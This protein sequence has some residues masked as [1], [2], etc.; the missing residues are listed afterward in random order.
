MGY[1]INALLKKSYHNWGSDE[2][3][4][5][6]ERAAYQVQQRKLT[7]DELNSDTVWATFEY[8]LAAH[9]LSLEMAKV[10]IPQHVRVGMV[11]ILVFAATVQENN[12][13]LEALKYL[14]KTLPATTPEWELAETTLIE[15]E[16]AGVD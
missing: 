9:G 8:V 14:T 16:N 1:D 12:T 4:R 11:E 6:V 7:I 3:L 13:A 2:S 10:F 5:R 15:L